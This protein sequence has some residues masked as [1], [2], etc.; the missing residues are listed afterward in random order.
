MAKT[1]RKPVDKLE[2][3]Q[4]LANKQKNYDQ[5]PGRIRPED[6]AE[7]QA[8]ELETELDLTEQ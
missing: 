8:E 7:F 5:R 4:R 1:N 3:Q 6:W 2:R